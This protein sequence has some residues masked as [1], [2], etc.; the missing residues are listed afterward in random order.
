MLTI[1][2]VVPLFVEQTF[3]WNSTGAG[4]IFLTIFIPSFLSP[5]IGRLYHHA[6]FTNN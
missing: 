3:G 6:K 5:F 2:Q 1:F 4:L